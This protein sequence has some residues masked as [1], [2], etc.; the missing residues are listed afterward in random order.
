MSDSTFLTL[1]DLRVSFPTE[2]GV[3]HAV[4][5]LSFSVEHGKTMAI[6][7]ESGSGKSVTAQAIMGLLNRD[8]AEISGEI[9]LDGQDLV[10]MSD[11]DVR[12]LRGSKMSMIFQD[13]MSS[14]HPYYRIGKQLGEAV[15][16]H[17]DVS[18]SEAR[19]RAIAALG[20]VGIPD[21]AKRV[22][23]YPHQL[24][25]GMR[26][27]VMIAMALI[28]EPELLIADEPT[29]ALDVTVQAQIIDL[30]LK[31]QAETGTTL[32]I[33]T[34]DLGVVADVADSVCVMYGGRMVEYGNI[35]DIYYRPEMPYTHG[36]LASV[37]RLDT[38]RA[39]RLDPIPG[40][41]PSLINLPTG[42]VFNPRCTRSGEVPNGICFSE[43]PQ[44]L[45]SNPGHLVRCH[46]PI[47]ARQGGAS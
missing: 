17:K 32:L 2:D 11:N 20:H 44:L 10:T 5:G 9:V 13:P 31:L 1:N 18:K 39:E 33:I 45:E 14:L 22:D 28:N 4:E 37:P 7:G 12:K 46:L 15:R 27:R 3:V 43:Q 19:D 26:Q 6:V 30:M 35:D 38:K 23:D 8:Q 47:D 25:G 40:N 41:P 29:T 36:L 42:C 16:V 34:H 24:S 21:P